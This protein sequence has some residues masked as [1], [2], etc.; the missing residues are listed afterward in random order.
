MYIL[1][2][3]KIHAYSLRIHPVEWLQ[4]GFTAGFHV[5]LTSTT[6]VSHIYWLQCLPFATEFDA[7]VAFAIG[8]VGPTAPTT[9][10]Y[11]Q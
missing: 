4:E 8:V 3:K 5:P 11:L 1:N 9:T 7:L 6:F 10:H 2:S